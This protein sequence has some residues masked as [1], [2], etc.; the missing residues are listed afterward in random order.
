VDDIDLSLS[1]GKSLVSPRPALQLSNLWLFAHK[2]LFC[3]PV[4]LFHCLR[5]VLNSFLPGR[6]YLARISSDTSPPKKASFLPPFMF[7]FQRAYRT[8]A[9]LWSDRETS[10]CTTEARGS[11][12][13]WLPQKPT[14]K[15]QL[16]HDPWSSSF[17]S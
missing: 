3:S 10:S 2:R 5:I 9:A 14:T 12:P 6:S 11:I 16:N 7:S 4:K 17:Q 13:G 15:D 8:M 1:P